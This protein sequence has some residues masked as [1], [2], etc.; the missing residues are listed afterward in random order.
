M[1]TSET[2]LIA[3]AVLA[4]ITYR[5]TRWVP[6][7]ISKLLRMPIVF[8]VAGLLQ[9][10]STARQLPVGW[11][12]GVLDVVL[13]GAELVLAVAVGWLMGRLT[14]IAVIGTTVSA[15]LGV[16]GV[17]VWLGFVAVRIGLAIAGG[18]LHAPLATLPVVIFF[19]VAVI[20]IT[21][22]VVVRERLARHRVEQ[23]RLDQVDT[24]DPTAQH[25]RRG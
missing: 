24:V 8:V 7:T 19:V 3:L 2:I 5:Q 23:S 20:K 15:R 10:P 22:A 16:A 12:L 14:E 11:H 1:T 9:I 18:A 17:A 21:Q 13:I 4:F 6:V 25:S